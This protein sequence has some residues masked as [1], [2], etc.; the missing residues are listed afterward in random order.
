MNAIVFVGAIHGA[1]K[2]TISPLLRDG[3]QLL[4]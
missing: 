4:V 2:T 1:E 3:C